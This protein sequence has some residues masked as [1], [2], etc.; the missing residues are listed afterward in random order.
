M[1]NM[2][3]MLMIVGQVAL[4]VGIN[5]QNVGI[6]ASSTFTPDASAILDISSSTLGLLIP[7]IAANPSTTPAN[8]LLIYNTTTNSLN[9]NIGTTTTP[10][11]SS[12]W[13]TS[14]NILTSSGNQFL[15]TTNTTVNSTTP[16][17][18]RIRTNNVER[19]VIDSASGFVGIGLTTGTTVP[20]PTSTLQVNGSFATAVS[21]YTSSTTL[22]ASNNLVLVSSAATITLPSAAA[23]LGRIYTIKASAAIVITITPNSTDKI[24]GSNTNYIL[25]S[26][27]SIF[28]FITIQSD[29][30]NWY[31]IANN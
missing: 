5:A 15:G 22:N 1:K 16:I 24:E 9:A 28:K 18:L 7:R 27:S 3:L 20:I 21:A 29:G 25:T 26:T 4:C 17:S 14:G 30:T 13:G 11:W 31:I 8:G 12:L 23:N 19:M 2:I 10:N 6:S